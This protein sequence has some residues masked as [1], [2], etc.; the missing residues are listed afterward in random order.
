MFLRQVDDFAVACRDTAISKELIQ[1]VEAQLQVPLNNLST[2]S[3]FN[4]VNVLQ[5]QDFIKVSCESV[6]NNKKVLQQHGWDETI[7]QHDPI[8][9]RN[10]TALGSG[11]SSRAGSSSCLDRSL[12]SFFILLDESSVFNSKRE[13]RI[14][15]ISIPNSN[16]L[17]L[18]V[19]GPDHPESWPCLPQFVL[20]LC[21]VCTTLDADQN[22]EHPDCHYDE[23]NETQE[24][25]T[26]SQVT[27]SLSRTNEQ[28]NLILVP[29]GGEP[30][31]LKWHEAFTKGFF[32]IKRTWPT[33]RDLS[34]AWYF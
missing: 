11:K 31:R 26:T 19:L 32:S 34:V 5:T 27:T 21:L 4:R 9:M 13:P 8:L 28:S 12:L 6:L 16:P 30:M 1:Q 14:E 3:K 33:P 23:G 15:P 20:W 10:Y 24:C 7:V 18:Y 29:S 17:V 25:S 2:L 22:Q